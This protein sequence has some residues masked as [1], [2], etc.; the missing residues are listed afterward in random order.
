[1]LQYLK[2]SLT[3][4]EHYTAK[5]HIYT[6]TL[7][8][9]PDASDA[10]SAGVFVNG[11]IQFDTYMDNEY[12]GKFSTPIYGTSTATSP[13]QVSGTIHTINNC[14]TNGAHSSLET[15]V[16]TYFT[17]EINLSNGE[18]STLQGY[19]YE[20][21][22]SYH[23]YI[24]PISH[25]G[26]TDNDLSFN[27]VINDYTI[28][29]YMTP[30]YFPGSCVGESNCVE[31]IAYKSE[32]NKEIISQKEYTI[33]GGV[34]YANGFELTLPQ[35]LNIE[36]MVVVISGSVSHEEFGDITSYQG[37]WKGT[38]PYPQSEGVKVYTK[39]SNYTE[40]GI[41]YVKTE[42]GYVKAKQ[43]IS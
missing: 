38:L 16:D 35:N 14:M 30:D 7:T 23:G 1:M 20:P 29:A 12:L 41:L 28:K 42:N 22:S 27:V 43:F 2:A 26:D 11:N 32:A 5:S 17:G 3:I 33:N 18:S 40:Y 39:E 21:V 37:A 31:I 24:V 6:A 8:L 13:I 15:F 34:S 9:T 25:T 36:S 19:S 4:Q 10:A